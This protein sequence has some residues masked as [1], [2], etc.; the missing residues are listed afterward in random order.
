MFICL[1]G[2]FLREEKSDFSFGS[3]CGFWPQGILW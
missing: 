1:V 3:V 2:D